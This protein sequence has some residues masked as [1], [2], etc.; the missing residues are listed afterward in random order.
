M[1]KKS[2]HFFTFSHHCTHIFMDLLLVNNNNPAIKLIL[3]GLVPCLEIASSKYKYIWRVQMQQPLSA[4]FI[5]N[6]IFVFSSS[7]V[8]V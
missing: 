6:D 1:Q 7:Y 4:A 3:S 5:L 2:K 8:Y